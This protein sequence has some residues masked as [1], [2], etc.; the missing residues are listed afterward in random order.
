MPDFVGCLVDGRAE[1][2]FRWDV[3][4]TRETGIADF[5]GFNMQ[6]GK[7][8]VGIWGYQPF[9]VFASVISI[10]TGGPC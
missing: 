1:K 3:M 5:P 8:S 2:A 6:Y 9:G 4:P 10:L 7:K